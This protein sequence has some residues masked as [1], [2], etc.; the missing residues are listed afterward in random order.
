MKVSLFL[1]VRDPEALATA[2]GATLDQRP[3][4]APPELLQPYRQ[5]EAV[6][7]YVRLFERVLA[8]RHT[9]AGNT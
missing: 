3:A 7:C 4:A 1:P 5:A 2:I 9:A 6:D 8:A